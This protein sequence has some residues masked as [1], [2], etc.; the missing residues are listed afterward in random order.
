LAALDPA[1]M[2][3]PRTAAIPADAMLP[4]WTFNPDGTR[5]SGVTGVEAADLG[6]MAEFPQSPP[7][8]SG[9]FTR[10]VDACPSV[11]RDG[12]SGRHRVHAPSAQP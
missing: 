11:Q 2:P 12:T 1:P 3:Y 7:S 5:A 8:T 10:C 4:S 6:A 9:D